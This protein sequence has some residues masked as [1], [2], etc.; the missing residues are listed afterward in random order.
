[1]TAQQLINIIKHK[2]QGQVPGLTSSNYKFIHKSAS[3][4]RMRLNEF[5][6]TLVGFVDSA[7]VSKWY[8]LSG[9]A[10]Q[11]NVV[12]RLDLHSG[13]DMMMAAFDGLTEVG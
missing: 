1:M 8:F 10:L 5:T 11:D 7:V 2:G 4:G 3:E 13:V 12:W 9:S 6:F